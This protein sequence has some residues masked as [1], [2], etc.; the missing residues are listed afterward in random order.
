MLAHLGVRSRTEAVHTALREVL[1][2]RRFKALAGMAVTSCVEKVSQSCMDS[3]GSARI[4]SSL[5]TRHCFSRR[6]WSMA[7]KAVSS[8][9]LVL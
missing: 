2:S 4:D 9:A 3:K 5:A 7:E 1:A 6:I 8:S